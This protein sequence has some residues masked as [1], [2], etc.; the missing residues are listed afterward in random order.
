LCVFLLALAFSIPVW[1]SASLA[2]VVA[3]VVNYLLCIKLLL[4]AAPKT[5]SNDD[6][7]HEESEHEE[8][9]E[10]DDD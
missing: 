4:N 8:E 10:D 2:F 7:K 5:H 3:A 1:I 9:G 6:D